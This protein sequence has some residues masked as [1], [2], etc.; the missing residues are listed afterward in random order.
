[1]REGEMI[2]RQNRRNRDVLV[3]ALDPGETSGYACCAIYASEWNKLGTHKSLDAARLDDR[4][5]SGQVPTIRG[6]YRGEF[7]GHE[8]GEALTAKRLAVLV[9]Q[10]ASWATNNGFVDP[11]IE[12]VVE[13]F[14]IRERTKRRDLLSPVRITA[15][16]ATAL[17]MNKDVVCQWETP[18]SPSNMKTS[19][20]D[21]R[22]KRMHLWQVGQPHARDALK[23]LVL[24]LRK[25]NV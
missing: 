16:F 9:R 21:D 24:H 13:D 25:R 12:V 22:L 17:E 2:L 19:I 5:W 23:H 15:G 8:L 1:M 10:F 20:T 4:V 18:Q 11:I 3:F 14:I 7:V 6:E